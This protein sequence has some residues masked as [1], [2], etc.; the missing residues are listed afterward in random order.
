M[1]ENVNRNRQ[2]IEPILQILA[3]V[4]PVHA[5]ERGEEVALREQD[6]LPFLVGWGRRQRQ[7]CF[8]DENSGPPGVQRRS[9]DDRGLVALHIDGQD[10]GRLDPMG[11]DQGAD[12]AHRDPPL[13]DLDSPVAIGLGDLAIQRGDTVI[14]DDLIQVSSPSMVRGGQVAG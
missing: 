3:E 11:V 9:P 13:S 7:R 14:A 4:E 5:V 1:V 8:H 12:R 2:P 10:V 6:R